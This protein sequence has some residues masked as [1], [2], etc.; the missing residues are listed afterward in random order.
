MTSERSIVKKTESAIDDLI[1]LWRRRKLV[2]TIVIAIIFIPT[3]FG[4]YQ[5]FVEVPKLK[6]DIN[7]LKDSVQSAEKERDKAET[8]LAPFLAFAN[9]RFPDSPSDKRLELLLSK[10]DQVIISVQ[11]AAR[12]VSSERSLTPQIQSLL[13]ANLETIP[14]LDVE[15]TCVLGDTESFVLASQ[16]KNVFEKAKWRVN[17]VNQSVF[18]VPIKHLVL[19]FGKTPSPELKRTLSILFDSLGYQREAELDEKL[20]EN[21]LKIVVG[22]K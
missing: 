2:C 1:D 9:Q 20:G 10:L 11:D 5:R 14:P 3:V 8:K 21:A 17:G 19:I 7:H 12:R 16:I 4:L 22:S 18:N 15:V 13:V 6:D